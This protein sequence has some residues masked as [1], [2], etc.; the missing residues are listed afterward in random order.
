MVSAHA[1][2]L[3]VLSVADMRAPGGAL[4]LLAGFRQRQMREQAISV[5]TLVVANTA[6]TCRA[7]PPGDAPRILAAVARSPRKE[8]MMF[9]SR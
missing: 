3:V 1:R 5:P 6:D 4:A 8:L 2:G 9:E 7:T